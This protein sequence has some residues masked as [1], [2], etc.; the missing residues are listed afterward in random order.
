MAQVVVR[1]V[2]VLAAVV[3]YAAAAAAQTS[4]RLTLSWTDN[5]TSE[6]GFEIER[7]ESADGPFV[8]IVSVPANTVRYEDT[9]IQT[10]RTYCYR[11]R[12]YVTYTVGTETRRDHSEYSNIA[13]GHIL[14]A[15]SGLEVI[16]R[17]LDGMA[18]SFSRLAAL[19][20]QL[21]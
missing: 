5:S 15:P 8:Q 2:P 16:A 4:P 10:D 9:Q 12:A 7:G 14:P 17:E 18:V 21:D 13:C 1:A 3:I 19:V 20:R 6:A 11:V